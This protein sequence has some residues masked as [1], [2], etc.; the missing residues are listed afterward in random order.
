MGLQGE[1]T[2][3]VND[4][5][6]D[7]ICCY[8]RVENGLDWSLVVQRMSIS[9]LAVQPNEDLTPSQNCGHFSQLNQILASQMG[10]K[11]SANHLALT[12]SLDHSWFLQP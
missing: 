11:T 10:L 7:V 4:L 3:S 1:E 8:C 12:W 9:T 5:C 6:M 2:C